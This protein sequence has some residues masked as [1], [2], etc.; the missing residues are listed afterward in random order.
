MIRFPP[1]FQNMTVIAQPEKA[2]PGLA[3]YRKAPAP[4][5]SREAACR[6]GLPGREASGPADGE[7][8]GFARYREALRT[9]GALSFAVPG[10]IGRLPMGMFSLAQV[11]LVVAVTGRYG[12]AGAVSALGA[13]AF[14]VVTPYAARLADRFGQARV[15]RP[16][17]MLFAVSTAA[18]AVCAVGHAPVWTLFL[19]GCLSRGTMPALG[20][21]VR[22]RWSR[23]LPGSSLLD[24]AFSLEGIA[25]EIIFIAGPVLVVA[26]V[27]HFHPVA[28]VL[29]TAALDVVGVAGLTRRRQTEPPATRASRGR[30]SVLRS[31]GLQVLIGTHVCLGGV[32]AAVD[33]ATIA[34]A[35]EHGS[36]PLAG[37]LLGLY[38]LG[39]A[40]AGVWYGARQ[41]RAP[42]SSRL[43]AALIATVLGVVP[44][45]F[46]PGLVWMA[47]A[48]SAAGLGISATLI[49]SYR[50]AEMVVPAGQRTEGMSW[51]TTAAS[52]GTALGAPVAGSLIDAHGAAAGYLFAFA[53]GLGG[54]AITL[55]RHRFLTGDRDVENGPAAPSS[56]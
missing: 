9:P 35:Q 2:E 42:H 34:F 16:L 4:A 40:I 19:T 17:V 37:L 50:L 15:L 10:F 55:V 52:V 43:V 51:L 20:S 1:R 31:R 53:I 46:V 54:L 45:A 21:M 27:T 49:S 38:G 30:G 7:A 23:L 14:A 13:L 24:A 32:F 25:D 3:R 18:L 6:T 5:H 48:I 29:V 47:V 56:W 44:L 28:G 41:W 36:K 39:S 22:S 33:L 11:M 8:S 12:V 26:L